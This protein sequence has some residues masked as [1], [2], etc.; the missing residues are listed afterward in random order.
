LIIAPDVSWNSLG[1]LAVLARSGGRVKL[2]PNFAPVQIRV[3]THYLHLRGRDAGPFGRWLGER[4]D[5]I[6]MIM[7]D[8]QRRHSGRKARVPSGYGEN[9]LDRIADTLF[10][11]LLP[12]VRFWRQRGSRK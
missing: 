4:S 1:V 5:V 12:G 7:S 11:L 10:A 6:Y 2:W 9:R 8:E 3:K